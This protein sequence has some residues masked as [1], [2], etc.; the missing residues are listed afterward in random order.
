MITEAEAIKIAEQA[1]SGKLET[2]PGAPVKV[3]I[4]GEKYTVIFERINPPNTLGPD[5]DAKVTVDA[6]TGEVLEI[7][8]G[9]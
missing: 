4:E 5:Y 2:Q 3:T 9:S 7:L 6:E 8:G 1:I